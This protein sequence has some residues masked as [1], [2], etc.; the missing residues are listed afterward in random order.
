[1]IT[2]TKSIFAVEYSYNS[3]LERDWMM[4]RLCYWCSGVRCGNSLLDESLRDVL[5]ETELM[6]SRYAYQRENVHLFREDTQSAFSQ[7]EGA[8]YGDPDQEPDPRVDEEGWLRHLV[9]LQ[10]RVFSGVRVFLVEG[11]AAGRL[12]FRVD[13]GSSATEATVPR[14]YVDSVL[15][16]FTARLRDRYRPPESK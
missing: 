13:R 6:L 8:L 1:M 12:L 5:F 9:S 2:G 7:L 15:A 14:G 10:G 11:D 3:D 16:E 4:G